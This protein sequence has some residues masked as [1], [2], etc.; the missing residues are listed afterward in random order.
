VTWERQSLDATCALA[1]ALPPCARADLTDVR[2][3]GSYY[4]RNRIGF[5]AQLFDTFGGA[6]P[7]LFSGDRT[8]R[9]DSSGLMLQL[10]GTPFGDAPQ[11]AR[12]TNL[13]LGVQYTIY[14]QFNGARS[15]FDGAGAN[16]SDNNTF[17]I[18]S[19]IAY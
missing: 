10:D 18:F 7:V 4:W 12:R 17:R 2:L 1:E 8:F 15:N 11:P 6:N 14:S 19:W 5:T 3:D 13:R 9:P 16:A